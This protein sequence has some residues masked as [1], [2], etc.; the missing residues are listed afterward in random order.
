MFLAGIIIA[1]LGTAGIFTAVGLE[2]KLKEPIY[3]VLMKI[4][5]WVIGIGLFLMGL[6]FRLG[7]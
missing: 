6:S 2:V 3:L 5:P 4:F 7:V 1:A